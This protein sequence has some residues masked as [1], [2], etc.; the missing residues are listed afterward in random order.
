TVR[1]VQVSETVVASQSVEDLIVI[2]LVFRNVTNLPS[3]QAVDP[4]MPA[5]GLR[6]DQVYVGFALDGDIGTSSDDLFSY[7]PDRNTVFMYDA[8][9]VEN[10]FVSGAST[11]PGL[12][13]L[14]ILDAPAGARMVLNGWPSTI[15]PVSGDWRAG[16]QSEPIGHAMLS[17]QIAHNPDH[18]NNTIGHLPGVQAADYRISVSAGPITLAPGDSTFLTVAVALADPAPGTFTSGTVVSSGD[19]TAVGRAIMLVAEPLRQRLQ[20]AEA[21]R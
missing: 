2:R 19:P 5:G 17:G 15:G 14:R 6:F 12:V 21:L 1:G 18:P 9:F 13:G 8:A 3:Y 20:A 4:L 10:A 11:R 16:F 7:D